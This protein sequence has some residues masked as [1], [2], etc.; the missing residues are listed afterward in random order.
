ME[1]FGIYSILW[2]VTFATNIAEKTMP[3]DTEEKRIKGYL[4]M[5]DV[6]A[7]L[8]VTAETISKWIRNKGMPAHKIGKEWLFSQQEIDEWVVGHNGN[9]ETPRKKR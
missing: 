6:C 2:C 3:D 4:K 5:R 8:S 7:Y 9:G 1:S